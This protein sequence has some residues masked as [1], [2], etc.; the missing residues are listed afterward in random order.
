MVMSSIIHNTTYT[1]IGIL[2]I[3][4]LIGVHELGHFLFCKLFSI[5]TPSFSIG[6]G[7]R[8]I[9]KK[10]G[11]TVFSL[12]AIPLGGYVEIAG[13]EE[14]GQGEQKHAHDTGS[15]SFTSK[16]YYQKLL[17]VLGGIIFNLLFAYMSIVALFFIGGEQQALIK[18]LYTT[19]QLVRVEEDGPAAMA[20][21]QPNDII[22]SLNNI[23]FDGHGDRLTSYILSHPNATVPAIIVRDGIERGIMITI[24]SHMVQ[25]RTIGKLGIGLYEKPIQINNVFEKIAE[26][27]RATNAIIAQTVNGLRMLFKEKSKLLATFSGP[28]AIIALTKKSAAAGFCTLL[29]FL[30]IISINLAIL[31]LLPIP[32]L[33]G[34]QIVLVTIEA[35]LGGRLSS[36]AL[37][38]IRYIQIATFVLLVALV[39]YITRQDIMYILKS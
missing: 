29:V 8:L 35:L 9:S 30:A 33:D 24:D 4:L 27:I 5:D 26:G 14:I 13:N 22:D 18:T 38:L 17:V 28:V 2:G 11:N 21:L 6:F 10:I 15:G 36:R 16:P 1:I 25:G 23:S 19:T 7:P 39:I 32:I 20:G 31:N 37:T 34:S 3:A 12:S